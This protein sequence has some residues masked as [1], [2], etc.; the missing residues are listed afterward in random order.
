VDEK[1]TQLRQTIFA[2]QRQ[3]EALRVAHT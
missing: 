1:F 3:D 2:W